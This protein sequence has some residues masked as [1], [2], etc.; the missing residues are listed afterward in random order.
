M[1]TRSS[2]P[3]PYSSDAASAYTSTDEPVS[4]TARR[5]ESRSRTSGRVY[6]PDVPE[7]RHGMPSR[8][9]ERRIGSAAAFARTRT[10]TSRYEA[11]SRT[12][13]ATSAAIQSASSAPDA[14]ASWRTARRG[15]APPLR[16]EL[17]VDARPDLEAVRVVV[18]DE[19]VRGVEDRPARAVVPAQHDDPGRLVAFAE[20]EDVADRRARNL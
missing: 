18:A 2:P 3:R 8:L 4:A 10:A 20:L 13:R 9:S 12:R 11:P 15:V 19:P 7:K 5:N 17:L 14:N 6:S 16:D 1:L